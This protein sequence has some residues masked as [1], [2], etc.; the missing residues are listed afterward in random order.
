MLSAIFL[1]HISYFALF[2]VVI[3]MALFEYY[4]ILKIKASQPQ[5]VGGYVSAVVLFAVTFFHAAGILP[6]YAVVLVIPVVSI[7]FI[8]ELFKKS[9]TSF[10]NIGFTFL[11]LIYIVLPFS[12]TNYLVVGSKAGNIDYNPQILLGVL[13]MI[14]ANDS[15]AYL[16]GVSLGK[17]KMFP[18]ISPKKSWEGFIGGLLSTIGVSIA[19]SYLFNS[20]EQFDWIVI[21]VLVVVFGTFG[22]LVE[23]MLKRNFGVKDSGN[24][25]PGHGGILDRFDSLILAIPMVYAYLTFFEKI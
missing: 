4:R 8:L 20:V 19:I 25:M 3:S 23:S 11:G 22:D 16:F 18:R 21:A 12:L 9:E 6:L 10:Q 7:V 15:F 24:I 2:I 1:S 17:N 14:W 5:I 13:F